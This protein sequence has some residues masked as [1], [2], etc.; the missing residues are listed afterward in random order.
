MSTERKLTQN[1]FYSAGHIMNYSRLS[2]FF[3]LS[4]TLSNISVADQRI[5]VA[6]GSITEIIYQLNQQQRI[7]GVDSTSK[8]PKATQQHPLLGYVRNVSAE[9]V[10]SLNPDLLI[11][12]ADTGPTKVV[13]QI[14][15]AGIK[16]VII[17]ADNTIEAIKNKIA[18]ISTLLNVEKKGLML[19]AKLQ[20]DLDALA[21][22]RQKAITSPRVLFLLNASNGAPIAAGNNT[23]ADTAIV[24]SGGI[25]VLAKFEGWEK[26][27][28]ESAIILN[29]DVIIIMHR[30]ADAIQQMKKLPHFKYGKAVKNNA[31]FTIDGNY[32]L[33]F[34]PRTPQAIIELGQMIH[35]EF[36]LPKGYQFL[37]PRNAD[38]IKARD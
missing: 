29:P 16:T 18:V 8:Y 17:E 10:L 31:V 28:P 9:G 21:Y 20:V 11:G 14:K 2:L 25:N 30:G 13:N 22:A 4:F 27:S 24:E 35:P 6:G 23:S 7:V 34:G 5:A 37:Y 3:F 26:L 33:G 36:S 1:N 19:L 38:I 12:E 15:A 32:L